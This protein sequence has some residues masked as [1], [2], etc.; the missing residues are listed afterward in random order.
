MAIHTESHR[1]IHGAL[2]HSHL[3][4]IPMTGSALDLGTDVGRVI[5]TDMGFLRPS[6]NPLPRRLF[7]AI[8]VRRQQLD[9]GFLDG[10]AEVTEHAGLDAGYTRDRSDRGAIM[11]EIASQ[12]DLVQVKLMGVG[13]RLFGR[14]PNTEEMANSFAY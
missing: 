4:E 2:G 3:T 5:E 13:N 11:T 12:S 10:H 8:V 14:R 9:L 6:I 1:M 7:E